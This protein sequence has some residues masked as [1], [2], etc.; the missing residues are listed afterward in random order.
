MENIDK[1]D[2]ENWKMQPGYLQQ[3]SHNKTQP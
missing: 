1:N 3:A 2:I